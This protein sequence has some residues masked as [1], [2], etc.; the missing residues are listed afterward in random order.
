MENWQAAYL[1]GIID[2]EGSITL[3]R[4]HQNE[5]RRPCISIASTDKEL[6]NYIKSIIGGTISRKKNYNP[7]KHKNSYMLSVKNKNAV[8][9]ILKHIEP[10]LRIRQKKLRARFILKNYDAVTPRNGKYT[11]V[12]LENKF[13]FEEKFFQIK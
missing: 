8:F 6:L 12:M 7:E 2:G 11:S 3:T 9:F 5:H 13:L 4:N 1:A 10:Y